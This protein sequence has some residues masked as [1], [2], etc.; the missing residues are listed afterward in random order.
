[1]SDQLLKQQVVEL[2]DRV[3]RLEKQ[4]LLLSLEEKITVDKKIKR[5]SSARS[6][7]VAPVLPPRKES[8]PIIIDAFQQHQ[9]A[10][11][12]YSRYGQ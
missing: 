4:V 9:S 1:M 2:M 3:A 5:R 7:Q 6:V 10:P 8:N 11:S 12:S